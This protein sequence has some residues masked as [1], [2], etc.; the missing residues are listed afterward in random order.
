MSAQRAQADLATLLQRSNIVPPPDFPLLLSCQK[1]LQSRILK[2]RRQLSPGH[3]L[4]AADVRVAE[5]EAGL[6]NAER[7]T[8]HGEEDLQLVFLLAS[9]LDRSRTKLDDRIDDPLNEANEQNEGSRC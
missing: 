4:R 9:D 8:K 3:R 2:K 7:A 5:A 1:K 6:A